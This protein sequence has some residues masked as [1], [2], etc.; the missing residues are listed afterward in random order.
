[1]SVES[2]ATLADLKALTQR[3]AA[4]LMLSR[5][6]PG[7]GGGRTTTSRPPCLA[8]S[9]WCSSTGTAS[10]SRRRRWALFARPPASTATAGAQLASACQ[11]GSREGDAVA[12]LRPDET[13]LDQGV[14]GRV[15]ALVGSTASPGQSDVAQQLGLFFVP[16]SRHS[17]TPIFAASTFCVASSLARAHQGY[18]PQANPVGKV[19]GN[20]HRERRRSDSECYSPRRGRRWRYLTA[21][22]VG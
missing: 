20:H 6:A 19:K 12:C 16:A 17:A 2:V 4:V 9:S 13:H 5:A 18:H 3:P 15:L 14:Q 22:R 10:R 8:P 1:M 7:D 11:S 21:N